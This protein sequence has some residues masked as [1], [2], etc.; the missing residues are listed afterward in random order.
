[1]RTSGPENETPRMATASTKGAR[2]SLRALVMRW[3]RYRLSATTMAIVLN[4][5]YGEVKRMFVRPEARGNGVASKLIQALESAA[6]D[7]GC[8]K[9]LLETGPY[10][11]QALAFYAKQGHARCGAFGSY[12]E[13]PLSVFMGKSLSS[14]HAS[15]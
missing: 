15:A 4:E 13:H 6:C 11:Q 7:R 10:Q 1:M 3:P 14:A 2:R 12:P 8:R 5:S 9:F